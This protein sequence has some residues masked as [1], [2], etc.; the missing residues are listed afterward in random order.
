[1]MVPPGT[2]NIATSR[3]DRGLSR[4]CHAAP[5]PQNPNVQ[6]SERLHGKGCWP[7][8]RVRSL[9]R[10][11]PGG[12][13]RY[14]EDWIPPCTSSKSR[15]KIRWVHMTACSTTPV[16]WHRV[17]PGAATCLVAPAPATRTHGSSGTATCPQSFNSRL[18][19]QDS[20]KAATYPVGCGL[21]K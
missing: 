21:L 11:G 15:Q 12:H 10:G 17:A 7:H 18:L 14:P 2:S 8:P 6:N 20:S 4:I 9:F 19:A 3:V 16:S 13:C 5:P 1:V